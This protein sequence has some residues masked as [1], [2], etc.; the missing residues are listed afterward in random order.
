MR[1]SRGPAA[2]ARSWGPA[3]FMILAALAACSSDPATPDYPAPA[4]PTVQ[5]S[6]SRDTIRIFWSPAL[7]ASTYRVEVTG[8]K[9]ITRTGI[10]LYAVFTSA[11]G[12]A[13][14]TTYTVNVYGINEQGETRSTTTPTLTTNFHPWDENFPTSLHATGQGKQTFYNATPNGGFEAFTGVPYDQIS[15]RTCHLPEFTGGCTACHE[16]ATP[17]LGAQVSDS[18]CGSACHSRQ[19]AEAAAYTDE[20]RKE[21]MGCMACH[22]LED[23]HGDGTNYASMLE[24]DA[25][26]A[27]CSRCH[28][29]LGSHT[30]HRLHLETVHCTACHTQSV[31]SCY[32]CHFETQ[33]QLN[34]KK[35]YGQ[36]RDWNFLVNRNGK[37][38]TANFQSVNNGDDTMVGMAPF[39]AHTIARNAVTS[40]S[41]CHGN[42]SVADWF[43]DGVIDVV[44]WNP[45]QNKLE[46]RNG[47]IPVPP[48]YANG[49]LRFDFVDLDKPGGTK[50]SFLKSG[51]DRIQLLYATPLSQ[52][53]MDKIR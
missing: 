1:S 3:P 23:V 22:T 7:G 51:A 40:C 8:G 48:N 42:A 37:V 14:A 50:W 5:A 32:N 33:V 13:D 4:A 44:T 47:I 39:Y 15:C 17:P 38:H 35:P 21:G 45:G 16:T 41:D 24:P 20:H 26:A 27:D 52:A 29:R 10:D 30:Y 12:V 18:K 25:I 2:S 19:A 31:I 28:K 9:S 6:T 36:F 53:Q 34:I 49:G 46:H 11:D 43:A